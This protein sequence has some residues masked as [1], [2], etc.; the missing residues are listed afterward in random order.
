ME[1]ADTIQIQNIAMTT[2]KAQPWFRIGQSKGWTTEFAADS[3]P[4]PG[5]QG[6]LPST[7]DGQF[8]PRPANSA[9]LASTR[10][11]VESLDFR[12]RDARAVMA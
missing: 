11:V 10:N 4:F 3:P 8:M 7:K 6:F 9:A 1:G 5:F 2:Q 12:A